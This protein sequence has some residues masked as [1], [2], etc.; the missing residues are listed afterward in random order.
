MNK[1]IAIL[2]G[3]LAFLITI[4]SF[5]TY[6]NA[7]KELKNEYEYSKKVIKTAKEIIYLKNSFKPIIPHFCKS[8]HTNEKITLSCKNLNSYKLGQINEVLKKSKII[9]FDIKKDK[10]I[11]AYLEISK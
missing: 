1:R 4:F 5:K 8:T 9:S 6:L 11:N 2:L 3:I 7:K 10:T